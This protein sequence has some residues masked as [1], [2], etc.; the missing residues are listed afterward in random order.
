MLLRVEKK[1]EAIVKAVFLGNLSSEGICKG[2]MNCRIDEVLCNHQYDTI[3]K[4]V[5]VHQYG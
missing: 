5:F 3:H 1:K 2:K 4:V